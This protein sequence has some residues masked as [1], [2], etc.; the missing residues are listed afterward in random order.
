MT[1]KKTRT[2]IDLSTLGTK[3]SVKGKKKKR[4]DSIQKGATKL[5]SKARGRGGATDSGGGP[6]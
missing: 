6:L 3:K 2:N 5:A 1:W 4:E